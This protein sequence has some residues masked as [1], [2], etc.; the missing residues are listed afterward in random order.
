MKFNSFCSPILYIPNSHWEKILTVDSVNHFDPLDLFRKCRAW[1][2]ST[3]SNL[4]RSFLLHIERRKSVLS[5]W[6]SLVV[7]M[8]CSVPSPK[9]SSSFALVTCAQVGGGEGH[10]SF[11]GTNGFNP[12]LFH[13]H[14]FHTPLAQSV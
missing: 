2:F 1:F 10:C 14:T 13:P 3:L 12:F 8:K 11:F 7:K 6:T 5:Q 9:A 4:F